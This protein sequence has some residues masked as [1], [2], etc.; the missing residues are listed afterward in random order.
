M[1]LALIILGIGLPFFIQ[2]Q[3]LPPCGLDY[4]TSEDESN[5]VFQMRYGTILNAIN[6]INQAK[7]SRHYALGCPQEAYSYLPADVTEPNL[8]EIVEIWNTN[9]SPNI[10]GVIIDC[11]RAGRYENN[12]ALGAY[13]AMQAGYFSDTL[14]L[15]E[16]A[17]MMYD[18][19]YAIWNTSTVSPRNEGVYGYVSVP[20]SDPCY[21][22]GVIGS[23]VSSVCSFLPSYCIT[24]NDGQFSGSSFLI[25][26]QD[27]PSNW[28]DGG[29]AYDHGWIGV[30][31][32]EASLQQSDPILKEK[33][34][35]SAELA[36]Q[37]CINEY[38]VKNHNYTAKLIW[39]LAQM[40]AW[41]GD[42]KY[43]NE[44][45]YKLNKNL[46]PGILWDASSDGIIEG[47]SPPIYFS[48]LTKVAQEPG[49]MWDAHNSLP[50]Y[51]AMNA[52]AIT[53]SY[54]SFRDQGDY[55]RANQLKPYVVAMIDNLA[56]E[57]LDLGVLTPNQLGVRDITYALLIAI[58]KIS[59]YE[60]EAHPNWESAAWAMWNTGYFNSY[61]T[62]TVCLGL[63]L[64]LKSE[65][66]FTPLHLRNDYVDSINKS[67][68]KNQITFYPTL[69][70]DI[71]YINS[72]ETKKMDYIIFSFTGKLVKTGTTEG[73]S[74]NISSLNKGLYTI[75]VE[76]K[77]IGRIIKK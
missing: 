13:Y 73:K 50:W 47:T 45:N 35:N 22:G 64:L 51:H 7:N 55:T 20:E 76:G 68:K 34:K 14:K 60:D 58:W 38:C 77:T 57:I 16:I 71:I 69:V 31:M 43:S 63:Y 4:G 40:Y 44:L 61:S 59:K 75:S 41:T 12:S 29:L 70:N 26:G 11:P 15:A 18:Q 28:F 39:L 48:S 36:A 56:N 19:Q 25:S 21:P 53:E 67:E 66:R 2:S 1:K 74:I 46:I 37:Y 3:T 8:S 17:D 27:D 32:I 10:S 33:Y 9:H 54:V 5:I 42:S 6:S 49:R 72:S 62:H 52:W 65:T 30:Q 23:S 24:F